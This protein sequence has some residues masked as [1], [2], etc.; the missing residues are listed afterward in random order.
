M[1]TK[2]IIRILVSMSAAVLVLLCASAPALAASK[3][4]V[5]AKPPAPDWEA[6]FYADDQGWTLTGTWRLE[7]YSPLQSGLPNLLVANEANAKAKIKVLENFSG[8]DI[9]IEVHSAKYWQCGWMTVNIIRES[10]GSQEVIGTK[11]I[12]LFYDNRSLPPEQWLWDVKVYNG[13]FKNEPA[14]ANYYVEVIC[15]GRGGPSANGITI[16]GYDLSWIH[17]VNVNYV[18]ISY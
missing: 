8:G 17:F 14:G 6:T 5:N 1:K 10:G 7:N 11:G 18:Y 9:T 4:K 2:G 3:V 16:P 13:K 12:N 15:Q